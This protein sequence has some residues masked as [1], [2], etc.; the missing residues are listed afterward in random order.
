[1]SLFQICH[2]FFMICCVQCNECAISMRIL[3]VLLIILLF[4]IRACT[5]AIVSY[6]RRCTYME[7]LIF[8]SIN[9]YIYVYIYIYTYFSYIAC[10]QIQSFHMALESVRIRFGYLHMSH[11][12][13]YLWIPSGCLPSIFCIHVFICTRNK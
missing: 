5:F 13:D 3:Q 10:S 2:T 9:I 8:T 12:M 11:G 7:N 1:M 4:I 6:K